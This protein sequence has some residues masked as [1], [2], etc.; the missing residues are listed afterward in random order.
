MND[1]LTPAALLHPPYARCADGSDPARPA[2]VDLRDWRQRACVISSSVTG[3]TWRVGE[4]LAGGLL[5]HVPPAGADALL[6]REVLALGFWVRRGM[7]DEVSRQ[8]WQR[9]R[10]KTVFLFGTL[11][12]WPDSA[13]AQQCLALARAMIAE[14][15]NR[16]LGE[17][18][19]QGRVRS[20]QGG[21]GGHPMTEERAARLAEAAHHPDGRDCALA[22]ACWLAAL[23]SMTAQGNAPLPQQRRKEDAGQSAYRC[24]VF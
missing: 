9:L 21:S 19:C 20:R 15:G 8:F 5:P 3:N 1:V 16:L 13:H 23:H 24:G 18:L 7:P 12:A 14:G 11:G 10:G 4:S 22:R 2:T 6:D 17:F